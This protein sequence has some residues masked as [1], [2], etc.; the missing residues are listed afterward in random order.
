M[1]PSRGV[2]LQGYRGR[3]Q[4]G[5]GNHHAVG[6]DLKQN[7]STSIPVPSVRCRIHQGLAQARSGIL[8]QPDAIEPS[9]DSA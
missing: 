9:T 8:I 1:I 6:K 2:S 7:F 5:A 3:R 4:S